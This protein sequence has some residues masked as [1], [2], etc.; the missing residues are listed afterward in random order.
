MKLTFDNCS[1]RF[2]TLRGAVQALQELTLCI[3]DGEFFVLLGPSGC[4]K[5]TLLNL[6][7]GLEK[8]SSGEIRF[9]DRLVAAPRQRIFV[10]PRDRNVAMVFQ[11]YALYPHL[12]VYENIAFPLRIGKEQ[13]ATIDQEVRNVADLL[14]IANLLDRK[15]GELSGGQRQRVA[16][17]R[18]L[19]RRPDVFLLDEPLS[20]LDAQLRTSTRT[21]LKRLQKELRITTLYVTHDQTE[22]MTLGDRIA[23]LRQGQ[24][25]QVG[26]PDDLYE[27]PQTPFAATF[28]GSPPM[29]L[30]PATWS[31]QAGQVRVT[32]NHSS[33]P[34]PPDLAEDLR[35]IGTREV[36]LG[37]RPEHVHFAPANESQTIA[38]SVSAIEP[39]GRETLFHVSATS[40]KLLVLSSERQY[41]PGEEVR[42]RLDVE[43][44]HVFKRGENM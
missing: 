44:L 22:A 25:V 18:A 12:S 17:A 42:V 16:I 28:V 35:R 30:I 2:L 11:S 32:F 1:K 33:Y 31:E 23:L 43:Q 36:F 26:T 27:R 14:G 39:L 8:P 40:F 13:K 5:S 10:T 34:L 3:E 7:A 4:G 29:N 15:P 24:L 19:V 41:A 21:E 9:G 38:G 6:A 37:I 20:N